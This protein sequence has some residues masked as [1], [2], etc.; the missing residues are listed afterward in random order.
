MPSDPKQS[1]GISLTNV[2]GGVVRGNTSV[3]HDVGIAAKNT[4]SINF[5]ENLS[6]GLEAAALFL[7]IEAAI[8]QSNLTEIHKHRMLNANREMKYAAGNESFGGKYKA[9]MAV[10][11]DHIQVLGPAL[12][13]L[14]PGLAAW[15]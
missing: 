10:L 14:L 8:N 7:E 2:E 13:P 6:I 9:F 4:K 3:G 11:A 5:I 15:L 12:T 1:I